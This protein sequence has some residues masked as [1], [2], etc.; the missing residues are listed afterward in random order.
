V[1]GDWPGALR[2]DPG[3]NK[4]N[5]DMKALLLNPKTP[6]SFWTFDRSLDLVG[7]K[8]LMPP[9]GL[10]TVAALLPP[11]WDLRLVDLEFRKIDDDLW[12]WAD[13]VMI[14]GMVVQK[15]S[16]K[17]L[18]QTAKRKGKTVVVGGPYATSVPQA[19]KEAGAD[20]VFQG[21][22]ESG[23][24]TLIEALQE[25]RDE[26][27][28]TERE[29]PAM[30]CSPIPRYDL[31]DLGA[32]NSMP[33]QTSRG[34]P[35]NCEFCDIINLFGRI[36]RY[37]NPDQVI[38]ELEALYRLGWNGGVFICD[39]NFIG[40]K[41]H[42]KA[43]LKE[44]TPWMEGH[45]KP[46]GFWTQ[47][48]VNLGQDLELIDLM[49]EA[50]FGHVFIGIESPDEDV[51]NRNRKYQNIKNPLVESLGNIMSNGLTVMGSFIIGFDG[52]EKG[53][54]DRI[55]AFVERTHIPAVM[56]NS[57]QVPPNTAL[58]DRLEREDRLIKG[59]TDGQSTGGKLNYVPT[60]PE[61]EIIQEYL[62]TVDRLFE[63]SAYLKRAYD[64]YLAM[65]PT[66]LALAGKRGEKSRKSGASD[67]RPSNQVIKDRRVRPALRL[68]WRQGIASPHRIQFWK[69]LIGM[70]RKNPSRISTYLMAIALGEN[71]FH[72]RRIVRD[73][74]LSESMSR[75]TQ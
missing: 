73:R 64:Y 30:T 71:L 19:V 43:I 54:D 9:L 39:D 2:P 3:K 33:V 13:I 48:S 62:S 42:A 1:K 17:T 31:L 58:W 44:L 32:Y 46:F 68:F 53:V 63:P 21:E 25:G 20:F 26:G 57:L 27:V 45:G 41:K 50:N 34:C 66:R 72:M 7:R 15:D 28:F 36:P 24:S 47:T 16:M 23:L 52:E 22:A 69:Q 11:D 8:S 6:H 10:L 40:N 65:R 18:I 5:K 4:R 12:N 29:K 67:D 49:T 59:R 70:Y 74:M 14:S 61:R 60:R 75:G 55:C 51:L 37:K 38:D 35:F 56:L